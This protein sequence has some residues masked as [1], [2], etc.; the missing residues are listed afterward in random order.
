MMKIQVFWNIIPCLGLPDHEDEDSMILQHAVTVYQ[1]TWLYIQG[2][3]NIC[4]L[5]IFYERYG[6]T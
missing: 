5:D 1:F 4:D 3:L 6:L 2:D